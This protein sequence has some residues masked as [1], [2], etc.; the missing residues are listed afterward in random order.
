MSTPEAFC[1]VCHS[2]NLAVVDLVAA[3]WPIT[4]WEQD[5]VGGWIA[6]SPPLA[7]VTWFDG[8]AGRAQHNA[9]SKVRCRDCAQR[10]DALRVLHGDEE[11]NLSVDIRA[12]AQA[13]LPAKYR[14]RVYFEDQHARCGLRNAGAVTRVAV[15]QKHLN[16]PRFV[17]GRLVLS[18]ATIPGRS[19]V[20]VTWVSPTKTAP[21]SVRRAFLV[22]VGQS[23]AVGTTPQLAEAKA[24]AMTKRLL[25]AQVKAGANCAKARPRAR[26]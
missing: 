12:W 4:H 10:F 15:M 8:G 18:T 22:P 16:L 23:F 20:E 24:A 26:L 2:P 1:F 14:F 5:S 21:P 6:H 3:Y 17:D 9:Q 19:A 25:V 11:L 7:D 13:H